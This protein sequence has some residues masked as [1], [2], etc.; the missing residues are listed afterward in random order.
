MTEDVLL[1]GPLEL[2]NEW[3]AITKIA[4]TNKAEGKPFVH[5]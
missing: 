4:V 1:M 5:V 2:T 3:H